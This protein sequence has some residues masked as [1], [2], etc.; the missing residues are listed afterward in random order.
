[1]TDPK[2]TAEEVV[3][4]AE[5]APGEDGPTPATPDPAP[6]EADPIGEPLDTEADADVTTTDPKTG[7]VRR[8]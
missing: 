8:R 4:P 6:A 7:E 2:D 1:M 3:I 5:P